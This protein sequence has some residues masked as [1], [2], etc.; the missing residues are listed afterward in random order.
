[1]RML[2]YGDSYSLR[3]SFKLCSLQHQI[4]LEEWW[5]EITFE[6]MF[7]LLSLFVCKHGSLS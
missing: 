3:P 6:A 2:L 7:S 4:H 1:M 5:Q